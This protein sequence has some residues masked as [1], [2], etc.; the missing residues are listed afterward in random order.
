MLPQ[1][2]ISAGP[3]LSNDSNTI[4]FRRSHSYSE[5][6]DVENLK[7][8]TFVYPGVALQG[9]LIGQSRLLEAYAKPA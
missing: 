6:S 3:A 1:G 2:S 9:L 4:L 7:H 5:R 8:I